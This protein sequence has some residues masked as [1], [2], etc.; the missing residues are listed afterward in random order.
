MYC[1]RENPMSQALR[2]LH[3]DCDVVSTTTATA[4]VLEGM[5]KLHHDCP[6]RWCPRKV[7]WHRTT[8]RA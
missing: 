4:I 1:A 5:R 6:P 7:R 3:V 8:E 2:H